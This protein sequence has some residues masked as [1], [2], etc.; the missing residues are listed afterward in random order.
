MSDTGSEQSKEARDESVERQLE[1]DAPPQEAPAQASGGS[2]PATGADDVGEST[3]RRGEDMRDKDGKEAGRI[4]TG[5]KG[6]TD[7]P[8][9]ESTKRDVTGIDT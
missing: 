2:T 4:D 6:P 1:G 7:R 8:T 3:S 9:G 5:T